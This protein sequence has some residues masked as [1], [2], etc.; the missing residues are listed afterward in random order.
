MTRTR[1]EAFT[2]GMIAIFITIMVLDLRPPHEAS[3]QAVSA[4][5]P[6]FLT[7]VLS[8]IYLAIYWSNHHHL[9]H[10]AERVDGA[11]LWA[12]INLLFWLSLIPFLTG[13]MGETHFD[14][15]PTVIY[16]IDLLICALSYTLLAATIIRS[17]GPQSKLKA[18]L[19]TDWKGKISPMLYA[20]GVACAFFSPWAGGLFYL[21]VAVMW[22][23]PDRR[24]EKK[25]VKADP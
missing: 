2:D 7:Y 4:V 10:M 20:A 15:L 11:I 23:V 18:S 6:S 8:F 17:Q 22:L 12:N 3:W 14:R 9:L 25:I 13:W 21:A 16:G 24:I 5:L 19:G 1:L